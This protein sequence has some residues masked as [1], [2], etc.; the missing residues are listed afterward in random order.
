MGSRGR[1]SN[2]PG[3]AV[4]RLEVGEE[5]PTPGKD[6]AVKVSTTAATDPDP[7]SRVTEADT[8]GGAMA[9]PE[10]PTGAAAG[11]GERLAA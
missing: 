9:H 5:E 7:D 4:T 10:A 11:P 2:T 1:P 6:P 8:G 3:G